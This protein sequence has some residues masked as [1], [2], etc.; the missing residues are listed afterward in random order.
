MNTL[1]KICRDHS[2]LDAQ[3]AALRARSATIVLTNGTFDLLH[4]G[5]VRY[6]EEARS[7]GDILVVG[8]NSDASVR[9]Y[10]GPGR[11]VV[12]ESERA[13][14]L[15]ALA[16]VD[17]VILFD[18]STAEALITRVRPGIYA[19][20]RDYDSATLPESALLQRLGVR[21][22]F[23]GDKKTHAASDLIAKL[24]SGPKTP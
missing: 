13:E 4:V 17:H 24:R 10:K 6:L 21:A 16:A 18:E 1:H 5:H 3:L 14:I 20:G 23:V 8:L 15:A 22:A 12:P 7:L 9:R 19:K 2:E 11:P